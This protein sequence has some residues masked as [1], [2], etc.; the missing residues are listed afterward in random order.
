MQRLAA[1]AAEGLAESAIFLTNHCG[2]MDT[3][4]D[5]ITKVRQISCC[6]LK[7]TYLDCIQ[8]ARHRV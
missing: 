3:A 5:K 2:R 1:L 8:R 4:G 7:L 6:N